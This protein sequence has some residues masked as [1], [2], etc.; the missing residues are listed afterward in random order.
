MDNHVLQ[1]ANLLTISLSLCK[2]NILQWQILARFLELVKG[3]H[4]NL[5]MLNLNHMH[6]YMYDVKHSISTMPNEHHFTITF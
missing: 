6:T 4:A 1:T 2:T 5:K 3:D